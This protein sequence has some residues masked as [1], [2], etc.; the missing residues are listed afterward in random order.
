MEHR[1]LTEQLFVYLRLNVCKTENY[2][3]DASLVTETNS[4]ISN[5]DVI[6]T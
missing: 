3:S 1:P 2:N 5:T 6:L 4:K